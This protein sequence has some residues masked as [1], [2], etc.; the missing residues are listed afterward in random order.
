MKTKQYN[1]TGRDLRAASH[2]LIANRDPFA[3]RE[4]TDVFLF[5]EKMH[6]GSA[7]YADSAATRA[8]SYLKNGVGKAARR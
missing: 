6:K 4:L 8:E 3:R 1:T 5:A 2:Y 7:S